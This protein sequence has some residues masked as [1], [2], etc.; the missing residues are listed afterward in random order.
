MPGRFRAAHLGTVSLFTL[1]SNAE[2]QVRPGSKA[3]A[4]LELNGE[5]LRGRGKPDEKLYQTF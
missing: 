3:E 1:I 4:R 5:D 2:R